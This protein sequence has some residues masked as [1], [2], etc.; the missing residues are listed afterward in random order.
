MIF[1]GHTMG[2]PDLTVTGAADLFW[3]MGMQGIEIICDP[4]YKC[5]F[6]VETPESEIRAISDRIQGRGLEI[7]QLTPYLWKI[8]SPDDN[9]RQ[10]EVELLKE[11]ILLARRVDCN[12]VR[13]LAGQ[14]VAKSERKE[15]FQLLID[16]LRKATV[17][18]EKYNVQLNI[19][20]HPRTMAITAKQT[21]EIVR[22]FRLD[23][24]GIIYDQGN[25]DFHGGEH[26]LT[27]L[28][29]QAKHI[30]YVHIKDFYFEENKKR[31]AA[32]VGEGI[33]KWD[34]IIHL[35]YQQGYDGPFSFE[36]EKRWYPNQLPPAKIGMRRSMEFIASLLNY[37]EEKN[38][39]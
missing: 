11:Y 38:R 1:V 13:I 16:S 9:E 4:K 12:S 27:A 21:M 31:H 28:G 32:L 37:E 30:R 5:G 29:M 18:A 14:E 17:F 15:R 25:L 26:Y 8:N 34:K 3:K 2:T 33:V 6:T 24:I 35:L 23:C 36:Y 39:R 20:N 10:Q 7:S 22:A 19:E